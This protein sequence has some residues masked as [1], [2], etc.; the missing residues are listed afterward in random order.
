MCIYQSILLFRRYILPI[1][2][3]FRSGTPIR[4]I[5]SC[6]V[7]TLAPSSDLFWNMTIRST[8]DQTDRNWAGPMKWPENCG[9]IHSGFLLQDQDQCLGKTFVTCITAGTTS[10]C[11][12]SRAALLRHILSFFTKSCITNTK[13]TL[14][15]LYKIRLV[16]PHST[17]HS[18]LTPVHY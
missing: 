8:T 2:K 14:L 3:F 1:F 4:F 18:H 6:T 7:R 12:I 10:S 15:S 17:V 16:N 9:T 11:G 5:P 13:E